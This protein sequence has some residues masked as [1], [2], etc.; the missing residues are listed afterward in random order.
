MPP[1]WE[2]TARAFPEAKVL[3][4]E[5]PEEDWWASYSVTICK[6]FKVA[7]TLP[8]PPEIMATYATMD[9]LLFQGTFGGRSDKEGCIAVYRRNNEK[10]RDTIAKDRLLVFTPSDGWD[11]LCR[12]LNVPVPAGEFPRSNAR[13]EFWEHFGG[14]PALA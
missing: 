5:R 1:V 10:V 12:F 9:K 7:Q 8:I 3:H 2:H 6:F 11:P 13:D 14:E 4:N